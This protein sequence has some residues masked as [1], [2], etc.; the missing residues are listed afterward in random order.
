MENSSSPFYESDSLTYS[1]L[2]F[3]CEHFWK[4]YSSKH[5][6]DWGRFLVGKLPRWTSTAEA[7]LASVEPLTWSSSVPSGQPRLEQTCS[8]VALRDNTPKAVCWCEPICLPT[9]YTSAPPRPPNRP[10]TNGQEWVFRT[11]YIHAFLFLC[12]CLL[13]GCLELNTHFFFF[14]YLCKSLK[15]LLLP[16][17]SCPL[18]TG[19]L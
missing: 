8:A 13:I 18:G 14:L 17:Q 6:D 11:R 15:M 2:N 19:L 10:L 5:Q 3:S 16:I 12:W 4:C 9:H 1:E 7:P